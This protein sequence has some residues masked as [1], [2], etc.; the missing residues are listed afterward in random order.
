[1]VANRFRQLQADQEEKQKLL[2]L[3]RKNEARA[4]Q[5]K[6]FREMEEAQTSLEAQTAKLR[7]VEVDLEHL[8]QAHFAAGDRLH[9]AQGFLYQINSEIGSLEAQIKFVVES[10]TRLQN[11]IATLA[12]QRDQWL[13]QE[14]EHREGQEEAEMQLE[15]LAARAEGAQI[16][17]EVHH[18]RLPELEAAWRAGQEQSTASRARIMQVQQRI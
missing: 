12:A 9:T 14:Q 5:V 11:Q 10:R 6:F 7:S 15:E 4:E 13:A 1:A 8:R 3:M 18:E 16:A 2:W 17:V